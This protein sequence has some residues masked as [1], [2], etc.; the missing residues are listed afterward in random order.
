MTAG[1]EFAVCFLA[2]LIV[3]RYRRALYC[4]FS[5]HDEFERPLFHL[6]DGDAAFMDRTVMMHI[7]YGSNAIRPACF[8]RAA[9][10]F[11]FAGNALGGTPY[12]YELVPVPCKTFSDN[13][14]SANGFTQ[15]YVLRY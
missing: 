12:I 6:D 15:N 14:D 5:V 3:E 8:K 9:D 10:I 2:R 13:C 7:P 4:A 1:I 11:E